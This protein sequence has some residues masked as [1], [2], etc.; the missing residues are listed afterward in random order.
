[1]RKRAISK[2][3]FHWEPSI[4]GRIYDQRFVDKHLKENQAP[5][6]SSFDPG[7]IDTK[8]LVY[9]D[10][11]KTWF[12]DIADGLKKN[13]E[14]GFVILSIAIAYIEGNQQFREGKTSNRRGR[15]PKFFIRGMRRIFNKEH[16]AENILKEF[17]HQV[18]CGLFHNG[19]TGNKVSISGQLPLPVRN[20]GEKIDINPHKFLDNIIDD[21]KDY[22]LIL[23]DPKN[24]KERGNFEKRYDLGE[25]YGK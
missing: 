4:D 23:K 12:L 2:N 17:Y 20:D 16:V 9:E 22:I 6:E 13:N 10:R 24:K 14:A 7:D 3:Y 5:E 21:F 1:M 25:G 19:M 11:V 8:I 15:S 18:R